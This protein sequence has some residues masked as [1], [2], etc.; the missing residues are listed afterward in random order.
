MGT[1]CRSI[2]LTHRNLLGFGDRLSIGYLNT[3][4]SNSLDN[5]NYTLPIKLY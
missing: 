1:D 3:N 5:L 2:K 4:G